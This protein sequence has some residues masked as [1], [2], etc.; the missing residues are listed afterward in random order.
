M[1]NEPTP[2]PNADPNADPAQGGNGGE[3]D[4]KA[5]YEEAKANSR[6]WEE[7]AKANKEKADKYDEAA[8]DEESLE[9]RIAKLEADKAALERQQERQA[10]VAKVAADTGVAET[11]VATLNGD[12]EKSLTA[13]AQAIAGLMPKGAPFAPEAGKFPHN[14][15]SKTAAEQFAEL[16]DNA[17]G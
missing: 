4:Y 3:P 7:R 11:I 8:G 6:K 5:L 12:D 13:Q 15:A 2:N 14:P 10:L 17:L 1:A 9:A 16:I